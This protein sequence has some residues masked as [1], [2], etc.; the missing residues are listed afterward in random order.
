MDVTAVKFDL[1]GFNFPGF[2]T[3]KGDTLP[4]YSAKENVPKFYK[5]KR[6][7]FNGLYSVLDNIGRA[8][9][10]IMTGREKVKGK[11]VDMKLGN[12]T[13]FY[14]GTCESDSIDGCSG[15]PRAIILDNTSSKG[16]IPGI[17]NDLVD[18]LNP[19]NMV[20]AFNGNGKFGTKCHRI[21]FKEVQLKPENARI[22]K[23]HSICVPE[24]IKEGFQIFR[25]KNNGKKE[26]AKKEKYLC[27]LILIVLAIM[28][29]VRYQSLL[30]G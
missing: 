10:V 26:D 28:F 18:G 22:E 11:K 25:T 8:E 13:F 15:E 16:L 12:K 3:K 17:A 6:G 19:Q 7:I 23:D 4:S 30:L 5:P 24:E 20:D 1:P 29:I 9:A 21:D 2:E 14:N 27:I